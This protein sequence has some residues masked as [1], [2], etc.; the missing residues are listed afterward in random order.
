[1]IKDE[2]G[3]LVADSHN[4]LNTWKKYFSQLL[5]AHISSVSDVRETDRHIAKLLVSDPSPFK[6]ESDTSKLKKHK[7]PGTGQILQEPI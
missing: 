7:S 3:D 4:N 6:V 2:N 1:M 5:N